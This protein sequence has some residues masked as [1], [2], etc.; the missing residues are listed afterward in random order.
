MPARRCPESGGQHMTTVNRTVALCLAIVTVGQFPAFLTG[1]S[2]VQIRGE[3]E[4]SV[5]LLG[6][7]ISGFFLVS[8]TTSAV[9]GQ[10]V[11]RVGWRAGL[12]L[13]TMITVASLTGVALLADSW[14]FLASFLALA[15]LG[16]A[17]SQPAANLALVTVVPATRY[18]L[19]FGIKQSAIL[20]ATLLGGLSVPA[21]ALTVGWRWTYAIAALAGGVA[22]LA[23][24][25]LGAAPSGDAA[26]NPSHAA[27]RAAKTTLTAAT[28]GR[29]SL[30]A[31]ALRALL[32]VASVGFGSAMV[33]NALGAFLV[34][35]A[36]AD[37]MGPGRAGLLLAGSSLLG[38]T[39]RIGIGWLADQRPIH[40]LRAMSFLLLLGA[41]GCVLLAV[42][43][44]FV[45]VGAILAV[46]AGWGWPGLYN[47]AVVRAYPS[48]AAAATG[49]S[50]TG[51]YLGAALGPVLLG[52][53]ADTVGFTGLWLTTA[54]IALASG[55]MALGGHRAL[56]RQPR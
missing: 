22:A 16:N 14:G 49:V 29:R 7:A 47:L 32:L 41:T 21:V 27:G 56:A 9:A 48:V 53:V 39:V 30:P 52:L 25:G 2:A 54:A 28:D 34:S 12:R 51:I 11:E 5:A 46:G 1:A 33:G 55:A 24:F 3:L 6:L 23:T 8:A 13:G 17:L 26:T 36:V 4:F 15:G 19:V 10:L 38:L 42:G 43:P 35:S 45:V 50:Q 31:R 44:A 20:V 37:G 18:G 40:P